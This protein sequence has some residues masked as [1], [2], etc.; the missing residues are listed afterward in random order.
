MRAGAGA[1]PQI[2]LTVRARCDGGEYA[3]YGILGGDGRGASPLA[4]SWARYEFPV[5]DLPTAG[6]GDVSV[7]FELLS[8]GEVWLDDVRLY[9]LAF[10]PSERMELAKIITLADD[11]LRKGRVSECAR[12]LDGYW[13][14]FLVTNVPLTQTPVAVAAR[15]RPVAPGPKMEEAPANR[16]GRLE[17]IR[18]FVPQFMRF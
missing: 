6:L 18:K 1:R 11:K 2:R 3:R 13:P 4:Q 5:D 8:A 10:Q 9:D 15:P 17:R 12:L 16:Q 7:Q 14:Q